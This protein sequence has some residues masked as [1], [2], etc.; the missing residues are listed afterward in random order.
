MDS[1]SSNKRLA[2]NTL[3]LYIRTIFVM[4]ISLYT[5]R[6][7]LS[8][9]G[10]RDYGIY[11]IVGGVVAMFNVVSGA[12]TT[13][14]S[15]YITYELGSGNIAKLRQIFSTSINIQF[16]LCLI[17]FFLGETVGVWFLNYKINIPE[18]RLFA[19]NCVLQC[20][21]FSFL[22]NIMSIP[23]SS[24]I[25]AHENMSAFA[26]VSVVEVTLKLI[27]VI[28]L[29]LVL[30]D[31]LV[32]YSILLALVSL[33]VIA[34]YIVYCRKKFK[35]VKYVKDYD[36]QLV[37]EMTSFAGWGFLTNTAYLFNTQGINILI[38]LFFGVTVNAARGVA[39]QVEGALSQ[40]IN[41]FS[42]ALNPQITKL[43]ASNNIPEM[44]VLL[45][46]GTKI[47]YFLSLI[48]CLP[49]LLE[50]NF[51]LGV[52]LVEI[53]DHTVSFVR[54][55]ILAIMA[56]RIGGTGYTA[57]MATGKIK[58]YVI[59]MTSIGIFVFPLTYAAYFWGAPVETAYLI[60]LIIYIILD[61]V[62]LLIMKSLFAFDVWIF[63]REV[64]GRI[65]LV[66][67]IVVPIMGIMAL[68]IL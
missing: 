4:A 3:L 67:F 47:L 63:I 41:N 54:L 45:I 23:F 11:N 21:L 25:V 49:V 32:F 39:A 27:V 44:N 9:L 6:V 17:I 40:F 55:S 37:K 10:V 57:C 42:M 30:Y 19:A 50:T 43:Y 66:T 16:V 26:Y 61:F 64:F 35:E 56:D 28:L 7:V 13:S 15:R 12:L 59:W 48:I 29:S 2:K 52:W 5:S 60:F 36:K 58:K 51:I 24:V 22:L 68:G 1:I 65:I 20:S 46:L 33:I 62:R 38:N 18:G 31:K 14:I 8:T 34:I 53:P